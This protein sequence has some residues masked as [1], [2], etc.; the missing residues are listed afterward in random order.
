MNIHRNITP[1]ILT[2]S[3]LMASCSSQP[4][5]SFDDQVETVVASTLVALTPEAQQVTFTA[6][7][8]LT[9]AP[10]TP[11][12]PT[13]VPFGEIYVY[14]TAQNTNLRTNPGTFFS[15]SRVMPQNTKLRLLGQTH[16]GDW[17]HVMHDDGIKGWVSAGVVLMTYDGAPPPIVSPADVHEITGIVNTETG[18]PV[19][20]VGFAIIQDELRMDV[21][22]NENGHF[23]AYLPHTLSGIW[24]VAYV[25]IS[26]TSNTM[27]E[28][29][30]CINNVCGAPDPVDAYVELSNDSIVTF[31]WK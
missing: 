1:L 30:N 4:T 10:P 29:C 20:G 7:P 3:F 19:D 18:T 15:V 12:P 2:L 28:N 11:I 8:T 23:L 17:L 26:C 6:I 24:R 31:V 25:S 22:T 21:H 13:D 27:D 14:T 16:L 9:S 5:E